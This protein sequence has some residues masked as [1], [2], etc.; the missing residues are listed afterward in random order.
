MNDMNEQNYAIREYHNTDE[1]YVRLGALIRQ[2][3]RPVRR[4]KMGE[5]LNYFENRCKR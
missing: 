2:P 4:E 5:F 3:L 1:I